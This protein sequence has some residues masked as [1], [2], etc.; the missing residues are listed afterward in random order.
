MASQPHTDMGLAGLG[1]PQAESL[2]WSN[3]LMAEAANVLQSWNAQRPEFPKVISASFKKKGGKAKTGRQPKVRSYFFQSDD[4]KIPGKSK[5]ANRLFDPYAP[6]DEKASGVQPVAE[7]GPASKKRNS[8]TRLK[9]SQDVIKL[10]DR[11]FYLLQPPL[12]NLLGDKTMEFPFEPFPFQYAGIAFLFARHNAILADEM[13]LGKTM[14]SIST[15]RMLLRAGYIR[16]V[17]LI[18]PKPLVTNWQ[19]EF[20]TWAPEV[21]VRDS[22]IMDG[23]LG[24]VSDTEGARN[25]TI[26]SRTTRLHR[27]GSRHVSD[28]LLHKHR[29]TR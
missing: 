9:P 5:P 16:N 23:A 6:Q 19:R 28:C 21:T 11:L 27:L 10:E 20:K 24:G 17:L 1:L 4:D 2:R 18:C 15:V 8:R 13:G 29:K 12:E 14:Q 7:S 25:G 26:L 22:E 3:A